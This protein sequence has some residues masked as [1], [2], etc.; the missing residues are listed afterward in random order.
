MWCTPTCMF[1][2]HTFLWSMTLVD[3]NCRFCLLISEILY[4][5]VYIYNLTLRMLSQIN[6]P[7]I[8]K[9]WSAKWMMIR[10]LRARSCGVIIGTQSW[11][12]STAHLVAR[13][14]LL[15]FSAVKASMPDH[16]LPGFQLNSLCKVE[17]YLGKFLWFLTYPVKL[18][19][20]ESCIFI[21]L[22]NL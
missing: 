17:Y 1:Q 3:N 13:G 4:I 22:I 16:S 2:Y 18:T 11:M 15:L 5:C 12:I 9:S 7:H 6:L 14:L 20:L 21:R 19:S 10:V 8:F